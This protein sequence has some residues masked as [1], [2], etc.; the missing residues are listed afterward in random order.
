MPRPTGDC[1]QAETAPNGS[2]LRGSATDS[3]EDRLGAASR[4]PL[5]SMWLNGLVLIR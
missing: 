3:A 1:D 2:K 5:G 4:P